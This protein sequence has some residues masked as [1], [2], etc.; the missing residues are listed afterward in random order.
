[1]ER[2]RFDENLPS[3]AEIRLFFGGI[4]TFAKALYRLCVGVGRMSELLERGGTMAPG[5]L[6]AEKPGRQELEELRTRILEVLRADLAAVAGP[7][8]RPSEPPAPEK[9]MEKPA[10]APALRQPAAPAIASPTD[11]AGAPGEKA[12]PTPAAPKTEKKPRAAKT[13]RPAARAKEKTAKK[14]PEAAPAPAKAEPKPKAAKPEK[15]A[16]RAKEEPAK[17]KPQ[18]AAAPAK[19]A[20]AP[21]KRAPAKAETKPKAAKPKKRAALTKEEPAKDADAPAKAEAGAREK[22]RVPRTRAE[23]LARAAR[24][25]LRGAPEGLSAGALAGKLKIHPRALG[26]LLK[27]DL[28]SGRI[29]YDKQAEHYRLVVP[30][31]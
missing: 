22:R 4:Q 2:P 28:E 24:A 5:E 9:P 27:A 31:A 14:K 12:R 20:P 18:S 17:A 19:A 3:D 1:V 30:R 26:I 8:A 25:F 29:A 10:K 16:A 6:G 13:K 7:A 21:K 15:R 23:T 11:G